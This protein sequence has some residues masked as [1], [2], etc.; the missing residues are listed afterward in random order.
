MYKI[1]WSTVTYIFSTLVGKVLLQSKCSSSTPL[2]E[3]KCA[4]VYMGVLPPQCVT[5]YVEVPSPHHLNQKSDGPLSVTT[6]HQP[7][8]AVDKIKTNPSL[9]LKSVY[10]L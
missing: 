6:A 4:T 2:P 9:N 7:A 5:V 8:E 3:S 1:E 10:T